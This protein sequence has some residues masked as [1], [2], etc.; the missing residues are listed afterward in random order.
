MLSSQMAS[1]TLLEIPLVIFLVFEGNR[2]CLEIIVCV[3]PDD[4][5]NR[6]GIQSTAQIRAYRYIRSQ[7]QPGSIHQELAQLLGCIVLVEVL[8]FDAR[9]S[10]RPVLSR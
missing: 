1:H 9:I 3:V 6:G 4:C 10:M 2:E 8:V 7:T 5:G